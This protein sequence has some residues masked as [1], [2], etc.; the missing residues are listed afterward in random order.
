[1]SG[2]RVDFDSLPD[3][4]SKRSTG[5]GIGFYSVYLVSLPRP[6]IFLCSLTHTH[7]TLLN[8]NTA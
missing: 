7:V 2:N 6:I 8:S 1:M 4:R 5:R 3:E